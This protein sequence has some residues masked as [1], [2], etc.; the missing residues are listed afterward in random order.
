MTRSHGEC[1]GGFLFEWRAQSCY[2]HVTFQLLYR[3][4]N[5]RDRV[6][7]RAPELYKDSTLEEDYADWS[8]LEDGG[9]VEWAR[10]RIVV[11]YI[12][13]VLTHIRS[14]KKTKIFMMDSLIEIV[15]SK[16]KETRSLVEIYR[17][18]QMLMW[19]TDEQDKQQHTFLDFSFQALA[20]AFGDE[21]TKLHSVSY[22]IIEE[23]SGPLYVADANGDPLTP[24]VLRKL[25]EFWT[26]T[27]Q[28]KGSLVSRKVPGSERL[29][30][31]SALDLKEAAGGPWAPYDILATDLGIILGKSME[32]ITPF[33]RIDQVG[34]LPDETIVVS[35]AVNDQVRRLVETNVSGT[36]FVDFEKSNVLA[37]STTR[38]KRPV[39]L[40]FKQT[41]SAALE[42][43]W[44]SMEFLK[45]LVNYEPEF[46][47][48]EPYGMDKFTSPQVPLARSTIRDFRS[49]LYFVLQ[50]EIGH[51][52]FEPRVVVRGTCYDA[53]CISAHTTGR[54]DTGG[55]WRSWIKCGGSW[56]LRDDCDRSSARDGLSWEKLD[57]GTA[58]NCVY[59]R[60]RGGGEVG[61]TSYVPCWVGGRMPSRC[62]IKRGV[63]FDFSQ[64][65]I[66]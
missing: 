23:A 55:H 27:H 33:V 2:F 47:F 62:G 32:S 14:A 43:M 57:L 17:A 34:I 53:I 15:A 41:S 61:A 35:N 12:A 1:G 58:S 36:K 46:Y 9:S 50:R 25:L 28:V 51:G 5:V 16:S 64:L 20:T 13:S 63:S 19:P 22:T 48:R 18:V 21:V 26:L 31:R 66:S 37:F 42:G 8:R 30:F 60:F 49:G 10:N 11:R 29:E 52:D 40:A 38:V 56:W 39:K 54:P 6:I 45:Q 4:K 44:V 24:E 7:E 59:E 65:G 3:M